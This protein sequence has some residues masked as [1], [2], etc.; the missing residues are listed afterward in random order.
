MP[1]QAR[2][3]ARSEEHTSEL[4]SPIH[5]VCRLLLEKKKALRRERGS[6]RRRDV[7]LRVALARAPCVSRP[8]P[9]AA[10]T[11]TRDLLA[12]YVSFFFFFKNRAPP[13]ISPLPLPDPFPI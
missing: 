12:H 8:D 9:S 2:Q 11:Q 4:Q 10:T 3:W 13:E 6:G 7:G 5:L 1:A